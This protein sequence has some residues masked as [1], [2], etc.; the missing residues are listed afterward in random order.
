MTDWHLSTSRHT[1]ILDRGKPNIDSVEINLDLLRMTIDKEI[2]TTDTRITKE[3]KHQAKSKKKGLNK[4][5][6]L[7]PDP[8]FYGLN[9]KTMLR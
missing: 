4:T 9:V 6:L 8:P 3:A 5:L 2:Q 7:H 1:K